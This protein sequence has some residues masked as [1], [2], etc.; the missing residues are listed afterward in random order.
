M[1]DQRTFA[2]LAWQH[3][4]KVTRRERFLAEMDAVIPWADLRALIAP[5]YPKAG[6]GRQPIGLE[7][8]LRIYFLQQWFSLS[9]PMAEEA[10]HDSE[11]MRRFARVTLGEDVTEDETAI[12]RFP[13][14]L[15][16]HTASARQ[17]DLR[18]D[19]A[20]VDREAAVAADRDDRGR[21]DHHRRAELDQETLRKRAIRRCSKRGRA[22][23]GTSA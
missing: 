2:D 6:N 15:E 7:R 16:Q 19:P 9:D 21:D 13:H 18:H 17:A 11:A 1:C 10:L 23:S 3:K 14:L 5:H 12:L 20:P 8:M 22:T 4:G